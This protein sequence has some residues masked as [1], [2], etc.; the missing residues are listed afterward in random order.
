M[1][2][3]YVAKTFLGYPLP[4]GSCPTVG[5]SGYILGGG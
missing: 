4:G 5:V 2:H 3:F 1:W